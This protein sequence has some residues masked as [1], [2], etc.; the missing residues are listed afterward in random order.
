MVVR[1]FERNGFKIGQLFLAAD[2]RVDFRTSDIAEGI[3]QLCHA[4]KDNGRRGVPFISKR[5]RSPHAALAQVPDLR[6]VTSCRLAYIV[7]D[8]V[9][10]H[11]FATGS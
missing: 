5:T 11:P 2:A 7:V 8:V 4:G 9:G 3:S 6:P 10:M 1:Q